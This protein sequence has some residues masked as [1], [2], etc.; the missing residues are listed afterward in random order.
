MNVKI[1]ACVGGTAVR[2]DIRY[3]YIGV[4]SVYMQY[5]CVYYCDV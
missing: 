5:K 1:M 3:V 4:V 2:D